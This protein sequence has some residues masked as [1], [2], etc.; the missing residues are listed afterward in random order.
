MELRCGGA[1]DGLLTFQSE[2][3]GAG[4][5]DDAKRLEQP[6]QRSDFIIIAG[7]LR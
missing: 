3:A 7:E 4:E 5:F 2:P 1:G 6:E